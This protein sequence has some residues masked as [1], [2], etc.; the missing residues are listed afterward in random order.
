MPKH[1]TRCR[2]PYRED[3]REGDYAY[4]RKRAG[5]PSRHRP[6]RG[7]A[8]ATH[9]AEVIATRRRTNEQTLAQSFH[10]QVR[11]WKDETAHLSSETKAIA[12]PSYLRI[13]GLSRDSTG[14]GIERLLLHE[15]ESEPD[16]WF[17]ALK[18]IT[19][20]DPVNPEHDFDQSVEAWLAWGREKGIIW[21]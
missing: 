19:G 18:A 14:H 5:L 9:F 10:E 4:A 15:L 11:L 1:S 8:A 20:E 6:E 21:K 13:I 17:A 2:R 16:L 3:F 7:Y 12:H